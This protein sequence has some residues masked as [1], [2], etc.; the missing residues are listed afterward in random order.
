MHLESRSDNIVVR[1][2]RDNTTERYNPRLLPRH[3]RR[4]IQIDMNT[5]DYE[6][7]D[8]GVELPAFDGLAVDRNLRRRSVRR[9][10]NGNIVQSLSDFEAAVRNN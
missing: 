8:L 2:Y 9:P 3:R 6:P 1:S 4:Y 10:K 7:L 5:R